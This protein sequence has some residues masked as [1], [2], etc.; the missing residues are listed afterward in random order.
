MKIGLF[1]G[2]F[3]P[4]HLGHRKLALEYIKTYNPDLMMIMPSGIPPHKK[5]KVIEGACPADRL[6]MCKFN[7]N[8]EDK[9]INTVVSDFEITRD[10][11]SYTIDTLNY[12]FYEYKDL[13]VDL[14]VGSDM[15]LSFDSWKDYE[16]I[17]SLVTLIG[18]SRREDVDLFRKEMTEKFGKEVEN[19]KIKF[20][21]F[22]PI[23]ISSS[24]LREMISNND[25]KS[26]KYLQKN[27]YDYI[28][29]RG[30]YAK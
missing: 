18:A 12:L 11:K 4:P 24:K 9:N 8:F 27:V 23:K 22:D 1:G 25:E 7:F 26:A 14:I 30:L 2:S 3:N 29:S 28:I 10:K 17:F 5:N 20:L 21:D 6:E 19:G 16:K 15:A 13:Q